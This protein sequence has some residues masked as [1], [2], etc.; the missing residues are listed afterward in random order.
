MTKFQG[1]FATSFWVDIHYGLAGL[2]TLCVLWQGL[3]H[4]FDLGFAGFVVGLWTTALGND[5]LNMP[6]VGE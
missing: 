5:R 6:Q 4:A 1:W 3:H 2:G